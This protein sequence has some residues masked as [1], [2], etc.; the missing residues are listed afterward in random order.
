MML[1]CPACAAQYTIATERLMGRKVKVR[2]KRCGDAFPVDSSPSSGQVYARQSE[3]RRARDTDL[4]AGA[5]T[6]GAES[7]AEPRATS[8][9]SVTVAAPLTGERNESSV[10]FSLAA[11]SKQAPAPVAAK[12]TESSSLID[13]RAL[14]AA[15]TKADASARPADDIVNLSGGGAFVPLFG[16]PL[17]PPV[18]FPPADE[19]EMARRRRGPLVVG[20]MALAA[21]VMVGV[22][23]FAGVRSSH[24]RAL[25][26]V[27]AVTVVSAPLEGQG[28]GA[29]PEQAPPPGAANEPSPPSGIP[30]TAPLTVATPSR[31]SATS[32]VAAPSR[33]AAVATQAPTASTASG[34]AKCCPGEAEMACHMRLAAGAACSADPPVAMVTPAAPFDRAAAVRAMGISVAG[35]K[36]AEG[37]TGPG[38]VKVTFQPSGAV[39]AVVVDAPY[40]GTATGVCIAKR[41][42]S[43]SIPAFADHPLS[44]GKSFVIE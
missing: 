3:N 16:S 7:L 39:S 25:T 41:Y 40:A 44:A 28:A 43:V 4:F 18:T 37:P 27:P 15:N 24:T 38:R 10:L 9:A 22:A 8:R 5:A 11:L 14:A 1:T 36:R 29:A 19:Q 13:I 30:V 12:I 17:A 21:V 33:S 2:C 26:T 23:A 32:N 6:A 42:A 31:T 20:A 35:C 34:G